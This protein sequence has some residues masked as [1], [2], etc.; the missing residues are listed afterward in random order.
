MKNENET[1]ALIDF[2]D[3]DMNKKSVTSLDISK[4]QNDD[5]NVQLHTKS[6]NM[7]LFVSLDFSGMTRLN[8]LFL[9]F[10]N[11]IGYEK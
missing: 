6:I 10:E 11:E 9:L 4:I 8:K 5:D 1:F 2:N 7:W 3:L